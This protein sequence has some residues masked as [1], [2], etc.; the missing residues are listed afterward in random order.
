MNK[1]DIEDVD[2]VR[3]RLEIGVKVAI[4]KALLTY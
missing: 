1:F 2:V 4:V 3:R